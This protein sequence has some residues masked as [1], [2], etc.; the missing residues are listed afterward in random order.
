MTCED[1][2]HY[3]VCNAVKIAYD[4]PF[5]DADKCFMFKDKSRFIE[6]PCRV[7]HCDS[8][9]IYAIET[10]PI[11]YDCGPIAFD[12]SAIGKTVFITI[13]EPSDAPGVQEN[14]RIKKRLM[15]LRNKTTE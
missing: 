8:E 14:G 2:V 12:K 7:F 15:W 4:V 1:C 11:F 5:V 10:R 13:E 9:G 6:L 3:E